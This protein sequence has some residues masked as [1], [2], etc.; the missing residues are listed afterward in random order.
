MKNKILKNIKR[1]G[2]YML[3]LLVIGSSFGFAPVT[4]AT[5]P[6]LTIGSQSALNSAHIVVPITGSAFTIGTDITAL[7]FRVNYNNTLLTYTGY[8]GA[9][10][11]ITTINNA[12]NYINIVWDHSSALILDNAVF[13]SLNFD[14]IS[15]STTNANLNH[16]NEVV[17]DH[18]GNSVTT[19]FVDGVISLNPD[20]TPPTISSYTV[21]DVIISPNN[22]GI[23]DSS[24]IDIAYSEKVNADINIL[25]SSGV[26]VR[27]LYDSPAV[28]NPQAKV[29]NGK[30]NSNQVVVDGVYTIQI[31]G[32]DPAGNTVSDTSKTISVDTI[33]P[34]IT[35]SGT[36]PVDVTVGNSY[37]DA[38]ATASDN[39][40]G[41]ITG[42]IVTV[43]PVN[44][45]VIGTY[46]ITY[47]VSDTA[48]NAAIQVTRTVKMNA[49]PLSSVK[50]ITAFSFSEGSGT[51]DESAH[52]IAVTVPYDTVLTALTPTILIS[53]GASIS[54]NSGIAQDF[55]N[56]V[57]YTVT[58]ENSST[59]AYVVTVSFSTNP[60]IALLAA[61]R[62]ALVDNSIKGENA[63]LSNI[64]VALA[65]LPAVGSIN[66]SIITWASSNVSIVSSDGQT[67]SRPAFA[68]GNSTVTL[69]ATLTKGAV[70]QTK[71]FT[72]IVLKLPPSIVATV[73]SGTYAIN[74]E[75]STITGIP[76]GTSS[77]AFLVSLTKS[78]SHQTWNSS[79]LTNPVVT[80]NTLVVTAQDASTIKTYTLTVA[81]NSTKVITAFGFTTPSVTGVVNEATHTIAITVPNTTDVTV[82]APTI[83]A[84]ADSSVSPVSGVAQD[85]TSP[86]TYTVTAADSSTQTYVVSIIVAT[87]TQAVPTADGTATVNNTT[88]QVVIT[89]PTQIATITISSGTT[90]PQID[91]GSFITGGTGTL[92]KINITSANTNNVNIAIPASTIVTSALNTW[93]GVI[94]APTVTTVT[95]PETSGQTKTLST[96][97]EVG[98]TGAK[99]SF[100]KAVRILLPNQAGKRAG[101]VRTGITFTEITNI[102]TADNQ[103]AGDALAVDSECKIDVG[104]DL[105][106]WTKHFTSFATYTQ[107]TN[108]TNNGGGGG[109]SYTP[110]PVPTPIIEKKG[111]ANGDGKVDKY[112]F[113]L[114]MANWGKTGTST[115]DFNNDGKVDKYDFALLMSNWVL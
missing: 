69:T 77:S 66:S 15:G 105:V 57:T 28:T 113:A 16:S 78:E 90:N 29:W 23:K 12:G 27:D 51:I 40:D 53:A 19:S 74:D 67:I 11:G 73:T 32:T 91:V 71:T 99:L 65:N 25:D 26:K 101:Y 96:A 20:T 13:V 97:I 110:T 47:N 14:V 85:F 60:N 111:D 1:I 56:P 4:H 30:N 83:T 68:D 21:S 61:D 100:D 108:N 44:T 10:A 84:S 114:I 92:P 112:D 42:D 76:F 107:T 8:T 102:C 62:E 89:N 33:A 22:D 80:G 48:G 95:L 98:F 88:P 55:T 63:D 37:T 18:I 17:S 70:T 104:S 106:I 31:L 54:P 6:T 2:S 103:V 72:L 58:A 34:T 35:L 3:A 50:K 87:A 52:T 81:L 49:V 79:G 94:A 36:S 39:V 24:S 45:N 38:G 86:V 82:L 46:T 5:G 115:S 7:Q 9:T 59:Q 43:N 93:N 75:S 64:T 109:G 41:N